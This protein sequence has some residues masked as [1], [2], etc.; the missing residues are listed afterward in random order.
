M[1][2]RHPSARRRVMQL[3][4]RLDQLSAVRV[5]DDA[6]QQTAR[7]LENARQAVTSAL[8]FIDSDQRGP[9]N[10]STA[11][12]CPQCGAPVYRTHTCRARAG[13]RRAP[14]PSDF[15]DQVARARA[16]RRNRQA[17]LPIDPEADQ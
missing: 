17:S 16:E 11:P 12:T 15:A 13:D 3:L 6:D 10:R 5:D 9:V 14:K 4:D 1:S 8:A 7:A 2:Y